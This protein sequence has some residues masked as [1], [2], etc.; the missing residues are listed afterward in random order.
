MAVRTSAAWLVTLAALAGCSSK[1]PPPPPAPAESENLSKIEWAYD[2]ALQKL[3]RP[4]ADAEQLKPFLKEYGDPEQ[5]LR[6]PRDGEPY[7]VIYGAQIRKASGMPPPVWAYEKVGSGG[8]RWVMTVMGKLLMTDA[9]F[10]QAKLM[11]PG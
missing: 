8:K 5:I 10:A 11:K 4:P 6:S 1:R 2:R 7:V 9:E 3:G